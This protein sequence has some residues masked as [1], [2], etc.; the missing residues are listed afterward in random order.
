VNSHIG[1]HGLKLQNIAKG[2]AK[3]RYAISRRLKDSVGPQESVTWTGGTPYRGFIAR[4]PETLTS[5]FAIP[6]SLNFRWSEGT[7]EKSTREHIEVS[8]Y[9]GSGVGKVSCLASRV[10]KS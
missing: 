5:G 9:R 8:A 6:R 2:I 3:S 10:A 1:F 4:S 7:V